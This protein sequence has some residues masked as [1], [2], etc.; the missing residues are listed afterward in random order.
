MYSIIS[1]IIDHAWI[2]TNAGE[3][4][5]VYFTCCALIIVMTAM[6]LDMVVRIICRFGGIR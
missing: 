1:G 4:Q 2:S 3:Q 6:F 5:Y